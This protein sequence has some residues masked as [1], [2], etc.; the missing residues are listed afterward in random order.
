LD[1]ASAVID[2]FS[3]VNVLMLTPDICTGGA[4]RKDAFVSDHVVPFTLSE[5]LDWRVF[6]AG[7][8]DEVRGDVW[9]Q[10]VWEV[11]ACLTRRDKI[12]VG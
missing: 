3:R 4:E 10:G 5:A 6:M 2:H 9:R 11:I 12:G 7:G 8:A 1:L